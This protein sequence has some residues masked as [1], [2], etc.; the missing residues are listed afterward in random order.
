MPFPE[1]MPAYESDWI[2][3]EDGNLWVPEYKLLTEQP[4]SAVF[5]PEGRFL[6]VVDTPVGGRITDIGPDFVLGVWTG[7]METEQVRMY[8]LIMSN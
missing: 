2:T 5:D 4:S 8:R 3:D 7:E 6:G 1:T